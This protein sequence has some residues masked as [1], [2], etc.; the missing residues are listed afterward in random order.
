MTLTRCGGACG[1]TAHFKKAGGRRRETRA[2]RPPRKNTRRSKTPPRKSPV[3][4]TANCRPASPVKASSSA[5]RRRQ[6]EQVAEVEL[7]QQRLGQQ[8][9]VEEIQG[10]AQKPRLKNLQRRPEFQL[11][12]AFEKVFD[13]AVRIF[14]DEIAAA[15]GFAAPVVFGEV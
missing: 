4:I 8:P 9:H 11:A 13:G 1:E 14:V 6:A 5:Q 2:S 12:A 15:H 3:W 7:R 10:G